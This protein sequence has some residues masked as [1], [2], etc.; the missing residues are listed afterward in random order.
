M[1]KIAIPRSK[2][3]SGRASTSGSS[4][5]QLEEIQALA[6]QFFVERGY[7]HGHDIEDWT[8]AENIVRNRKS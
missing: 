4:G 6:Y 8:R 2:N 7:E 3:G 1:A 5:N